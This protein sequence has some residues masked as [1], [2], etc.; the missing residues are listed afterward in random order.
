MLPEIIATFEG[1]P[2]AVAAFKSFAAACAELARKEPENAALLLLLAV[3]ARQ[4][5]EE[6]EGQPVALHTVTDGRDLLLGQARE[7]KAA[8]QGDERTRLAAA[9]RIAAACLA[10]HPV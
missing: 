3:C 9:N 2:P 6:Y 7:V 10:A 8:F 4:F 1:Q 5:V